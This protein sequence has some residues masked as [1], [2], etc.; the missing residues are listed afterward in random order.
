[1][2]IV[3]SSFFLSTWEHH[4]TG[5]LYLPIIN[6]PVE[7]SVISVLMYLVTWW[8]GASVWHVELVSGLALNEA[9]NGFVCITAIVTMGMNVA[10]VRE[11]V[12]NAKSNRTGHTF[13]SALGQIAPG[14]ACMATWLF[15]MYISPSDIASNHAHMLYWSMGLLSC[16][17]VDRLQISHLFH[18]R[19]QVP[20]FIMAPLFLIVGLVTRSVVFG[21]EL[22]MS[23]A[24]MLRAYLVVI[25]VSL[26]HMWLTV[27]N[28]ICEF[29]DI[30]CLTI[31]HDLR[32][33]KSN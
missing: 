27:I 21:A 14:L 5:V 13:A 12:S 25:V 26:G 30:W 33:V 2:V 9:V 3:I 19:Y 6:G 4:H 23:E 28:A 7:G 1:M 10:K 11:T 29:L 32:E 8:W 18:E 15:W 16:H 22:P 24:E 17:Q 20:V 31:K